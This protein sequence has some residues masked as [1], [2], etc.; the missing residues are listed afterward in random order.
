MF[1]SYE[2]IDQKSKHS[3]FVNDLGEQVVF[4]TC[5]TLFW[6]KISKNL[7]GIKNHESF[8]EGSYAGVRYFYGKYTFE[9]LNPQY[10]VNLQKNILY[11]I[12][13]Y[14]SKKK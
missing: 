14:K 3:L 2:K 8:I 6:K 9:S 11:D 5:D 12:Y 10:G 4:H 13:L 1:K 7:N